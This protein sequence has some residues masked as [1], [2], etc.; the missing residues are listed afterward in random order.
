MIQGDWYSVQWALIKIHEWSVHQK[1]VWEL[2]EK[3]VHPESRFQETEIGNYKT[4]K[5][6]P[7]GF[8][9]WIL[10]IYSS[11]TWFTQFTPPKSTQTA[12]QDTGCL[13]Q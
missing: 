5:M 1:D 12:I 4:L 11:W 10:G 3:L 7:F 13:H 9:R 2:V 8:P 6:H